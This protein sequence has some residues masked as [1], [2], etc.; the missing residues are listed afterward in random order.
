MCRGR[1]RRR[2]RRRREHDRR[3]AEEEVVG[4]PDLV[5]TDSSATWASSTN[6]STPTSLFSRRL[7]RRATSTQRSSALAMTASISTST[8][9]SS[10]I[11]RVDEQRRVGG[12]DVAEQPAWA[13]LAAA[14]P[15]RGEEDARADDVVDR[16]PRS[17]TAS[18]AWRSAAGSGRRVAGVQRVARPSLAVVPLTTITFPRRAARAYRPAPNPTVEMSI[19]RRLRPCGTL[20]DPLQW[21]R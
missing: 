13:L 17:S 4:Q 14:S 10:P 21:P 7:V 8:R 16:P 12:T 15:L 1:S 19:C 9:K 20:T 11:R 2:R 5:E 18:R 3:R 6:S